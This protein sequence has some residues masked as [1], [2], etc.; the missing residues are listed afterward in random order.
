MAA[1]ERIET[2]RQALAGVGSDR[3]WLKRSAL[4]AL[5]N[6]IP[7]VGAVWVMGY[8]LHYQRAVI[9]DDGAA[10][11]AWRHFELQFKTGLYAFVAG[12]VYALPFSLVATALLV[13]GIGAGIVG[14]AATEELFWI[15]LGVGASFVLFMFASV[16]YGLVLWP[17]YVQVQL[18]DTISSAFD[19]SGIFQRV[20]L[21]RAAF[22]TAARRAIGLGL[23]SMTV[24][25]LLSVLGILGSALLAYSVLPEE[26]YAA[27]GLLMTPVQLLVAGIGS[28]VSIPL[29]LAA[30]RFWAGYARVAYGLG[31]TVAEEA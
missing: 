16:I 24:V 27:A 20:K 7:Y 18:H 2:V 22:W 4:G 31:G 19:F 15:A 26:A 8:G 10:L 9:A 30:N 29:N 17:V 6:V 25:M 23:I 28:L 13:V 21:H 12:L 1:D 5:I 3:A 11:P 14:T